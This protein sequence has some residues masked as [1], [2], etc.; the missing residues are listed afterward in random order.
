MTTMD[1]TREL[2]AFQQSKPQLISEFGSAWVV[3]VLGDLK[4]HFDTFQ[5]AAEFALEKYS[6]DR[7][8]IRHT[9]EPPLKIPFAAVLD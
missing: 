2:E 4:G 8:L 9:T 5:Q 3:F 7:F 6:D 1:L